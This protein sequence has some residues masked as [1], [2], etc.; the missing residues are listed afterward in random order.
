MKSEKKKE[1]PISSHRGENIMREGEKSNRKLTR[2]P[3]QKSVVMYPDH[4]SELKS[5][6]VGVGRGAGKGPIACKRGF[7]A[8]SWFEAKRKKGGGKVE[9]QLLVQEGVRFQREGRPTDDD[10][11][12]FFL[13]SL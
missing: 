12:F 8:V 10:R 1:A 11:L 2:M 5:S 3:R 6:K 9:A 7:A 13:K 4:R